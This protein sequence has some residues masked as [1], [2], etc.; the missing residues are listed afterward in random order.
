MLFTDKECLVE[1]V[2]LNL[3]FVIHARAPMAERKGGEYPR[4]SRPRGG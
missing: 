2:G 3:V 1:G 4:G